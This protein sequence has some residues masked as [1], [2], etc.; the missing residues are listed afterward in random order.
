MW[1]LHFFFYTNHIDKMQMPQDLSKL[2]HWYQCNRFGKEATTHQAEF[3]RIHFS[4]GT[5]ALSDS[6]P[7]LFRNRAIANS[8]SSLQRE[9]AREL[10]YSG[11]RA[12]IGITLGSY[13]GTKRLIPVEGQVEKRPRPQICM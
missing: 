6:P 10:A 12:G 9:L 7:A 8:Y 1:L 5:A 13:S 11:I 4:K 3:L 2:V